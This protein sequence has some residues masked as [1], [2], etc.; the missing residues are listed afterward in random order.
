MLIGTYIGSYRDII[1][2]DTSI[3]FSLKNIPALAKC[4]SYLSFLFCF[5]EN[6]RIVL[7]LSRLCVLYSYLVW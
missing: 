3:E 2:L 7:I 1:N 6:V 4:T 5:I